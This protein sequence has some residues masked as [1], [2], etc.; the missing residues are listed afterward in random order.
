M[1]DPRYQHIAENFDH[2][3]RDLNDTFSFIAHNAA[4]AAF[5]RRGYFNVPA[6]CF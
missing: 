3:K 2:M 6:G 1:G 5:N 4:S